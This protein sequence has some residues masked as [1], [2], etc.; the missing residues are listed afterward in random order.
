MYRTYSLNGNE[1][2]VTSF[3]DGD[4]LIHTVYS[5]QDEMIADAERL[6]KIDREYEEAKKAYLSSLK[7]V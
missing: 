5:S 1:K 6:A 2:Y 7:E 4:T 3:W